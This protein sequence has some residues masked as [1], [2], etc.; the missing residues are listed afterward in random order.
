VLPTRLEVIVADAQGNPVPGV[1]VRFRVDSGEGMTAPSQ[2]R[3]DATGRASA[4]WRLGMEDGPQRLVAASPLLGSEVAFNATATARETVDRSGPIPAES[5]DVTVVPSSYAIGGSHVCSGTGGLVSCR[6]GNDRGQSSVRGTPLSA[7]T[8]GGAHS[9]GLS[10]EGVA[11]CWGANDDGQLG[12]GTRNDRASPVRVR[13]ELRFSTLT[14]G[15]AHTCG[16]AGAGVPLCWGQNLSGQLGDGTRN[17]QTQPRTVGGGLSFRSLTAGW[18]H[19]CGLTANGNAFCW[20]LNSQGQLGDGSRLDRLV[21]TL[22]RGAVDNL[23]A[24]SAHTCGISQGQVLCWGENSS[25]QLG[26]GS[27]EASPQPVEVQGIQGTPRALAAGAVHTCVLT[28]TGRAYCWGQNLQGQLGDGSTQNRP[29][30]V[31]VA[32]DLT[33]SELHAGG[34]QTCGK[35]SDGAEYCWGLNQSGQLGDGSRVSRSTPTRVGS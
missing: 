30:A 5:Q 8:A 22:A 10:S 1:P 34:A 24:G 25:G 15:S 33:F 2:T 13:T 12:D 20:G 17:D 35:T 19:T 16:L 21:P 28:T 27:M 3:T 4:L 32:G 11:S 26:D 29:S 7:I 9:C 14:A 23:V 31:A 6:G 18:S